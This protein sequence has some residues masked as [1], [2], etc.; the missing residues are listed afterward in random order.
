MGVHVLECGFPGS[1]LHLEKIS[2]LRFMQY[3]K[4]NGCNFMC[5]H[6]EQEID[7]HRPVDHREP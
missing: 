1:S 7:R 6:T 3:A 5:K 2:A 4:G